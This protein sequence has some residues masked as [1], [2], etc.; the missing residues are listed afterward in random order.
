MGSGCSISDIRAKIP[1]TFILLCLQYGFHPHC[2]D[3]GDSFSVG[4]RFQRA[5][6]IASISRNEFSQ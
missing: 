6:A 3:L 5:V 1:R 2:F 4:L